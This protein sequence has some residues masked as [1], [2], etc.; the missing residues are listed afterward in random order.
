MATQY[1]QQDPLGTSVDDIDGIRPDFRIVSGVDALVA[2]LIARLR[3]EPELVRQGEE[4]YGLDLESL[5]NDNQ[6]VATINLLGLRV[7]NQLL[8]D[9]RVESI[10]VQFDYDE[11]AETIN[12]FI[13]GK[14][15]TGQT[16]SFVGNNLTKAIR[17]SRDY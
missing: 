9:P 1:S 4:D 8:L 7:R 2:D 17:W 13:S 5:V 10:D 6:D 3:G 12:M 15:V 11:S 14:A 16:F